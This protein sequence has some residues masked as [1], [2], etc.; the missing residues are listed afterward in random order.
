MKRL[1]SVLVMS[2]ACV[3]A[4]PQSAFAGFWDWLEE[5]SGPG[6]FKG[7]TFMGT[8]CRDDNTWIFSPTPR[9]GIRS[10]GR[11]LGCI[12]ADKGWFWAPADPERGF[13]AVELSM[14]DFGAGV[15]LMD[16]G[17]DVTAGVGYVAYGG[18]NRPG[19]GLLITP[20]RL[21]ARPIMLL[22]RHKNRW[23]G[24][25]VV[26]VKQTIITDDYTGDDF[27]QVPPPGVSKYLKTSPDVLGTFGIGIDLM[28]LLPYRF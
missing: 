25:L 11:A 24:L 22:S 4:Q 14:F 23:A 10:A 17:L 6:P 20:M 13:P 2:A 21:V 1:L 3:L 9:D 27:G 7:V 12:Y 8:A 26:H 16:G 19:N 5:Y 18:D 28:A 15:R